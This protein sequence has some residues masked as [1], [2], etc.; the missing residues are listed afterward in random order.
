LLFVPVPLLPLFLPLFLPFVSYLSRSFSPR[1]REASVLPLPGLPRRRALSLSLPCGSFPFAPSF[2]FPLFLVLP[3]GLFTFF[4]RPWGPSLSVLPRF[5]LPLGPRFSFFVVLVPFM[6]EGVCAAS[7]DDQHKVV[8]DWAGGKIYLVLSGSTLGLW[9]GVPSPTFV[10][11]LTAR[12]IRGGLPDETVISASLT[13]QCEQDNAVA[14]PCRCG[15]ATAS[16]T[17]PGRRTPVISVQHPIEQ[18]TDGT[19]DGGGDAEGGQSLDQAR[20]STAGRRAPCF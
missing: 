16:I 17:G 18:S 1:D 8:R 7:S 20:A 5:S 10:A 15:S 14:E 3:L 2:Y 12:Y 11:S 6:H 9:C 4:L 19:L 13:T